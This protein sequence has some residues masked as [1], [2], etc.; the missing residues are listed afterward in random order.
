VGELVLVIGRDVLTEPSGAERYVLAH[1]RAANA[2]GYEPR[3]FSLARRNETRPADFGVLHRCR[4]PVPSRRSVSA[5]LH[6]RWLVPPIVR[7]LRDRP[8]PHVIHAFGPWSNI[9][10]AASRRLNALGVPTIPVATAWAVMEHET[11]P[12]LDSTVVRSDRRLWLRHRLELAWVRALM[13]RVEGRAFRA[14]RVVVVNYDSV[15]ALLEEAYGPGLDIR[16]LPYTPP[17]A[18]EHQQDAEN[19]PALAPLD[20][21]G[22]PSAPLIVSVSRHDGRKGLEFLIRALAGLRDDGL[23]FRAC[24]LGTGLLYEANRRL[25]EEL[26]LTDRVVL[27]GG[28][29]DVMP[30]LR[31]SDVYVLPSLEE[32]SG[33]VAALEAMQAGTAIVSTDV[34]GMSE[35][36]TDGR[37]ALLVPP[38]DAAAL[39]HAIARLL[40]DPPL[41][42]H[43]G[44]AARRVYEQRF[45][46]ERASE[47]LGRFYAELGLSAPA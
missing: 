41:R 9:A 24:L 47:E 13:T 21:I 25:V 2:A 4:T 14:S 11:V 42:E 17:T 38:G 30:Y 33:S 31:R 20:G 22:D 46:P 27:A 15:R 1:A 35:D 18:Y 29:P 28:V 26:A 6:R 43:L 39:Q 45:S 44:S 16:R 3:V 34:D 12:K 40:A 37:D 36:L 32:A 8:G 19:P 5:R 23:S 10:V 7:H